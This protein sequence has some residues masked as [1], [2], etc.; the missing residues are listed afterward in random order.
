[1]ETILQNGSAAQ[2]HAIYV[3]RAAIAAHPISQPFT[4]MEEL[5]QHGFPMRIGATADEYFAKLWEVMKGFSSKYRDIWTLS[6]QP[7]LESQ[8]FPE[9][10]VLRYLHGE[11]SVRTATARKAVEE[12]QRRAA[13]GL[14]T[15]ILVVGAAL[16]ED[17]RQLA[18]LLAV[19][20]FGADHYR[21]IQ[22]DVCRYPTAPS[23]VEVVTGNGMAGVG[24]GEIHLLLASWV[25]GLTFRNDLP[26]QVTLSCLV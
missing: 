10:E 26:S 7:W 9:A 2:R 12:V 23:A 22:R 5:M 3:Q 24:N 20:G 21:I 15:I 25:T 16:G 14:F 8:N 18:A 19:L 1:M 17:A 6:Q 13:L 11:D 4:T